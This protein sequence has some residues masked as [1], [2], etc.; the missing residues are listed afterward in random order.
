VKAAAGV[1]VSGPKISRVAHGPCSQMR[2]P[3]NLQHTRNPTPQRFQ[4]VGCG[5]AKLQK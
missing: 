2:S 1:A 4:G 3:K 5:K